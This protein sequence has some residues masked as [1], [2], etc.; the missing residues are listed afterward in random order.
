MNKKL[1]LIS[2][3]FLVASTGFADDGISGFIA[4]L[5]SLF[6]QFYS[7][8]FVIIGVAF[9]WGVLQY[10]FGD[11]DKEKLKNA[12]IWPVIAL[13]IL[14]SVWGIV[15]IVQQTLGVEGEQQISAPKLPTV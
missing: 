12:L 10:I 11:K 8:I 6:S 2:S 3:L 14:M 4:T 9:A 15:K 5:N 13:I 1:I 7:L